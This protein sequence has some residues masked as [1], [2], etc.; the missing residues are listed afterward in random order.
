MQLP[1]VICSSIAEETIGQI[2]RNNE[3]RVGGFPTP[4]GVYKMRCFFILGTRDSPVGVRI[5]I[6][7]GPTRG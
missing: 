5:G 1:C 3:V 2:A 6:V 7:V 4:F